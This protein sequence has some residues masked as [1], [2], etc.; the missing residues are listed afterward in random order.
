MCRDQRV[1]YETPGPRIARIVLNRPDARNAQDTRMLYELN[2][3]FD[4]AAQDN[5]IRVIIL[6]AAGPHFSAGHDVRETSDEKKRRSSLYRYVLISCLLWGFI[7]IPALMK[8][9]WGFQISIISFFI[10]LLLAY[11]FTVVPMEFGKSF[12]PKNKEYHVIF[13]PL[14]MLPI[15]IVV[16]LIKYK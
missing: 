4:R 13:Y 11:L 5:D 2:D 15:S 3:A 6:A 12:P 14:I 10:G 7:F 16:Y 8:Y 1:V 9:F